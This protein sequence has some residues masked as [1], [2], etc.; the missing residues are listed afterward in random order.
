MSVYDRHLANRSPVF[1]DR[2][3][4]R[5]ST[6]LAYRSKVNDTETDNNNQRGTVLPLSECRYFASI[7][8]FDANENKDNKRRKTT[9]TAEDRMS[10]LQKN[11][12]DALG[13]KEDQKVL[14][15]K[16]G[17]HTICSQLDLAGPLFSELSTKEVMRLTANI[18]IDGGKKISITRPVESLVA[19]S[20]FLAPGLRND[21]YSNLI[22]WSKVG[23]KIAVGLGEN[24]HMWG[25]ENVI[26]TLDY[27]LAGPV[28]CVSFSPNS[29]M[30]ICTGN[31]KLFLYD[32]VSEKLL[33]RFSNRG[34]C[35]YCVRWFPG[36]MSKNFLIGNENGEIQLMEIV[37]SPF[38]H[39]R[40]RAK[41][42]CHQQQICGNYNF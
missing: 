24:T 6:S 27:D 5:S 36:R 19:S 40:Q 42:K 29:Y 2:Y 17:S 35:T 38:I 18:Q 1:V 33:T 37:D 12:A 4:P 16:N 15:Y 10:G 21:Y 3:I 20:T 28:T 25:E 11:I 31:G 34:I 8:T 30:I 13:Y 9:S 26:Q 41:F 22:S 23:N 7:G 14:E 39:L 32:H